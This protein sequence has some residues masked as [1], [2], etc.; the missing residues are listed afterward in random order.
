M[1]IHKMKTRKTTPSNLKKYGQDQ[2]QRNE[3][4]KHC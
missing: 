3:C 4:G 2:R 1:T